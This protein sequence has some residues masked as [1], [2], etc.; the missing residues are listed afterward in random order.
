MCFTVTAEQGGGRLDQ[1]VA[2][3]LGASRRIARLWISQSLV[4][5]NRRIVRILTRPIAAGAQ[6][7]VRAAAPAAPEP[8]RSGRPDVRILHLDRWVVVVAKPA[9]LLSETDRYGSPSLQSV[10]PQLLLARGEHDRLWLV[11]R[12][13]A[14]TSGVLIMARTP[15]AAASLGESFKTHA[16][17]KTYLALC[18]GCLPE[19]CEVNL[20]IAR[21]QGTR[22][23][24]SPGGKPALTLL[25][26]LRGARS[27]CLVEAR[28]R[29]GRTHQIRVHLSHL[30]YPILGDRLYGGPG[31]TDESPP[32]A[33][34]R[35]ML[36]A[37]R[38][39][40]PHPSD[41]APLTVEATPPGDFAT[42]AAR[43][44]I[45]MPWP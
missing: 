17:Q 2:Q 18:Q 7:V 27:A 5:V 14:G 38:L 41:G 35:P 13:D 19:P 11:H 15:G 28:P 4:E 29:T 31:Y 40:V 23:M 42:L 16:A 22:H 43:F 12:L 8:A 26:P 33:I 37:L 21:A 3:Q 32:A 9:G 6:I 44:G 30:G 25:R 45:D 20:P 24:V 36:H 34:G 39:V 1:L 10:V